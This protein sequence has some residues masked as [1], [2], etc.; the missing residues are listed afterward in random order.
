MSSRHAPDQRVHR[1]RSRRRT[2]LRRTWANIKLR[3]GRRS[4]AQRGTEAVNA[5][6]ATTDDDNLLALGINRRGVELACGNAVGSRQVLH[7][8]VNTL[9]ITAIDGQVAGQRRTGSQDNSV[10]IGQ[11]SGSR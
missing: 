11:V 4:L 8:L 1:P 7:S 9:Q 10:E 5:G 3:D 6:V 2:G